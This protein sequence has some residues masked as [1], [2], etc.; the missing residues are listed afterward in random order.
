MPDDYTIQIQ[1]EL[2]VTRRKWCDF[3]SYSGG[4]PM[5][6]IRVFPDAR[7]QAAIVEAAAAFEARLAEKLAA[8]RAALETNKGDAP[9]QGADRQ[10]DDLNARRCTCR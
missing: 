2:L 4:L 3:V 7:I 6:P 5:I 10:C 9:E 8:Y 1:T